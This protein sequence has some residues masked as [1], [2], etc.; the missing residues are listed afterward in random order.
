MMRSFPARWTP[1]PGRSGVENELG[2]ECLPSCFR[3]HFRRVLRILCRDGCRVLADLVDSAS[4]APS[5]AHHPG[6]HLKAQPGP[7]CR[8]GRGAGRDAVPADPVSRRS[9]RLVAARGTGTQMRPT[10]YQ[11]S[12][13][14]ARWLRCDLHVHTSF[15]GEKKFGEDIRGAIE[16]FKKAKPQRLAEIAER[17]V[18][19][20]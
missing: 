8:G 3:A 5:A 1:R 15:D 6:P 20:D 4:R 18:P 16:T 9:G 17:F 2:R 7:A 13:P 14:G 19:G 11:P 10:P 12:E